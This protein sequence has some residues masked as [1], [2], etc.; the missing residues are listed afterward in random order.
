MTLL[1]VGA[2]QHA[3]HLAA[4]AQAYCLGCC[5]ADML[6]PPE[7]FAEKLLQKQDSKP[8]AV[9]ASRPVLSQV[10][11]WSSRVARENED[12]VLGL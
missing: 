3:L 9:Q 10:P 4:A 7:V 1:Q 11:A 8:A 5:L 12:D 2:L 6:A